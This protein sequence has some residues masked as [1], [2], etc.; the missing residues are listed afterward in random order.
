MRTAFQRRDRAAAALLLAAF[1]SACTTY[2]PA[3]AEPMPMGTRVRARL[4]RPLDVP[5]HDLT[6]NNVVRVDGE[7]V[8]VDADRVVLS[9]FTIAT[10]GGFELLADGQTVTIPR[11][12]LAGL[13]RK[14]VALLSTALG[15]GLG[16]LAVVLVDAAA[17][18][19]GGGGDSGGTGTGQPR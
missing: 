19:F 5:L 3:P 6:A 12:D 14:K 2:V 15:V 8:H 17:R 1:L 10:S 16:V 11:R 4:D 7:V 9:A 13:E 18:Q